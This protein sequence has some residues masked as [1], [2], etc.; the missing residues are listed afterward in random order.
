[1]KANTGSTD[2]IIRI[3]L[4][5]IIGYY[6][7]STSFETAWLQIVLYVVASILLVTAF[8]K[9]CPLYTIFGINTCE[10]KK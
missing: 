5:I 9:F 3:V 4:A 7:Y 1:M 2:R 10:I 6:A 8:L